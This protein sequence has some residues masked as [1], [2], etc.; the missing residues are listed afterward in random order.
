VKKYKIKI[1]QQEYIVEV[2]ELDNS[3][4]KTNK[5]MTIDHMELNINDSKSSSKFT[6]NERTTENDVGKNKN[7]VYAQIPGTIIKLLREEGD[8]VKM[9]DVIMI[10]EAM[11]MENEI[12][13]PMDGVIKKIHVTTS[14][15]VNKGDILFEI[16]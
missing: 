9:G 15:K 5:T 7:K 1:N 6:K 2:E 13:S 16:E 8:S 11:K 14:Q 3:R 4:I 10:I 12:V